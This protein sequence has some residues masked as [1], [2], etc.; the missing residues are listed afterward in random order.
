MDTREDIMRFVAVRMA[1]D[2]ISAE[3]ATAQLVREYTSAAKEAI[4]SADI[5][6]EIAKDL[7]LGKISIV[8]DALRG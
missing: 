5:A 7:M 6:Y 4:D 1:L 2:N 8:A 3:T